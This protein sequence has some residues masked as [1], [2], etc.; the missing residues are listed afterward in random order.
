MRALGLSGEE[1]ASMRWL[2]A[3]FQERKSAQRG[4]FRAGYPADIR[5]SFARISRPKTCDLQVLLQT[6]KSRKIQRHKKSDP[7][8]TFGAPAKVP[9]KLLKSDS[10]VTKTVEEVTF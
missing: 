2:A 7:K 4:S 9:Q 8:V 3:G 6:P 10:K 1:V 5:G